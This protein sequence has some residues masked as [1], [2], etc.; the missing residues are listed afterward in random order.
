MKPFLSTIMTA[1][2]DASTITARAETAPEPASPRSPEAGST[3]ANSLQDDPGFYAGEACLTPSERA[4]R[5]IWYKA[6][7]GN[8][9]FHINPNMG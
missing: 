7:A 4:G 8:A 6:T 3:T 1:V 9:R 5:E 2:L